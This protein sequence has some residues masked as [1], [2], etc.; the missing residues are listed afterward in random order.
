MSVWKLFYHHALSPLILL[1][2]YMSLGMIVTL[3]AWIAARLVS[4]KRPTMKDS[5][6]SCRA[7]TAELWN[8]RS[9]LN[10]D[11]ISRTNLWKGSF[12]MSR[13]VDFWKRL[14][15]RRATVPGLNLWALLTPPA[16]TGLAIFFACLTAT[17]F[18]GAFP[19]V[20][21][22]AVCL[23]LAI[24]NLDFRL[25][26]PPFIELRFKNLLHYWLWL[27][28]GYQISRSLGFKKPRDLDIRI[29]DLS[30][31]YWRV[32][33]E[34]KRDYFF[35]FSCFKDVENDTLNFL[36]GSYFLKL[37]KRSNFILYSRS[38]TD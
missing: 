3:L 25:R 6:A 28:I 11:A 33:Q 19:P 36:L 32:C 7:R 10:S 35:C 16:T 15:S 31:L 29:V 5:V 18:L 13:S 14:I 23:V 37:I 20:F 9:F 4:S 30:L 12:L 21:F 17:C 38:S 34:R 26:N 24:V 22:L 27:A 8:L 2:S 1:A